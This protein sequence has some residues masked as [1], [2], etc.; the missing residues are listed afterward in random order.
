MESVDLVLAEIQNLQ[1]GVESQVR[2]VD[3][4]NVIIGKICT[5]HQLIELDYDPQVQLTEILDIVMETGGKGQ[6]SPPATVGG[7][8]LAGAE[9]RI[10][11]P[12]SSDCGHQAE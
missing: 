1:V 12:I 3:L 4:F 6:Q 8:E 10:T 5:E 9:E 7:G 2:L 11:E